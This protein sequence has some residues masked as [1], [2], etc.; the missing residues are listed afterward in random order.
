MPKVSELHP[1]R[2]LGTARL[3][4]VVTL[5][6]VAAVA[7]AAPVVEAGA[8]TGGPQAAISKKKKKNFKK[9]A[10]N[11]LQGALWS[12]FELA[13]SSYV[14]TLV[15]FCTNGT[16]A[17][18]KDDFSSSPPYE[19]YFEGN[20]TVSSAGK[21]SA[22]LDYTIENFLS[23]YL[24]GSPGPDTYPGSPAVLAVSMRPP[25]DVVLDGVEFTRNPG[26]C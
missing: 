2:G 11:Y 22:T 7:I 10:Q 3:R 26:T 15:A 9:K 17:Y 13:G 1:R 25:Y 14:E 21:T 19:T 18:R 6:A 20:W 23:I 16:Y 12:S 4:A 8:A 24:D 5:L